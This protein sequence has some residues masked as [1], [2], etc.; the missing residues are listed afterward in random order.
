MPRLTLVPIKIMDVKDVYALTRIHRS[1]CFSR[2][3]E[4]LLRRDEDLKSSF[5]KANVRTEHS[6]EVVYCSM[7][8][9]KGEKK[10]TLQMMKTS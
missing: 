3:I 9:K 6:G 5:F 1:C 4:A 10:P 8:H 7:K 2:S